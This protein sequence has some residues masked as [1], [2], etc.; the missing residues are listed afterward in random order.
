[1]K[2]IKKIDN[3]SVDIEKLKTEYKVLIDQAKKWEKDDKSLYDFNAISVNQ[4]EGDPKSLVGSN[5]RGLYWT[6]PNNDWIEEKR[7]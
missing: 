4:K 1:M 7:L 6:Y 2:Y 3:L 5:V